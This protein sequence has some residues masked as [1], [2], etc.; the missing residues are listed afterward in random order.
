MKNPFLSK[1]QRKELIQIKK[2]LLTMRDTLD[3]AKIEAF[4]LAG[5]DGYSDAIIFQG[6]NVK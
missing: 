6:D 1:K 2:T 5:M 3:K 4:K